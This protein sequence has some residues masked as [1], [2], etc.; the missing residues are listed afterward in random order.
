MQKHTHRPD[1]AALR[2]HSLHAAGEPPAV[3]RD[4]GDRVTALLHRIVARVSAAAN[5]E[6]RIYGFNVQGARV[7]IGLLDAGAMRVGEL[8]NALALDVSTLS[9]LLRRFS[10]SNLVVRNRLDADNRSV[11]VMLTKEGR[12]IARACKAA[13]ARHEAILLKGFD[14]SEIQFIRDLLRRICSNVEGEPVEMSKR[15]RVARQTR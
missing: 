14:A 9:H 6:F 13:R 4:A 3:A 11:A 15:P 7:L 5:D 12:K 10:R 2:Q 8:G 1:I